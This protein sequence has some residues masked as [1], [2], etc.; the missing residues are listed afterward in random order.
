MNSSD[1]EEARLVILNQLAG[2]TRPH[3]FLVLHAH[4]GSYH[5]SLSPHLRWGLR[6]LRTLPPCIPS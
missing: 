2:H 4:S 6:L 1:S 3:T 5:K